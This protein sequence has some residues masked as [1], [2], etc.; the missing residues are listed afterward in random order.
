MQK[1][2]LMEISFHIPT[3]NTQFVSDEN[4]P[5]AQVKL[6]GICYCFVEK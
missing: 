3:N 4:R 1:D 2:S 5:P 6:S